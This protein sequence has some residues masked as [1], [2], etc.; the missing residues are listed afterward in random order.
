MKENRKYVDISLL[1]EYYELLNERFRVMNTISKLNYETRELVRKYLND[2]LIDRKSNLGS[3]LIKLGL[4]LI[5][6]PIPVISEIAGG[7]LASTGY[8]MRKI[9]EKPGLDDAFKEASK[10]F[11]EIIKTKKI[12][13]SGYL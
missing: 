3:K 5:L 11:E 2:L 9:N 10:V 13:D 7:I 6:I 4:M 8:L 12:L 1:R